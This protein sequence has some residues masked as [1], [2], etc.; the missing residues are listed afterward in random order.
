MGAKK[1][2]G[3]FYTLWCRSNDRGFEIESCWKNEEVSSTCLSVFV[4]GWQQKRQGHNQCLLCLFMLWLWWRVRGELIAPQRI[5][6]FTVNVDLPMSS[7][8]MT[9]GLSSQVKHMCNTPTHIVWPSTLISY[10]P[11]KL[12]SFFPIRFN[13][14]RI[15]SIRFNSIQFNSIQFNSIQFNLI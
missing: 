9:D 11:S 15:N 6:G 3:Y 2:H 10:I 5:G 13:S 14:I 8:M 4:Q 12:A 1:S 7:G